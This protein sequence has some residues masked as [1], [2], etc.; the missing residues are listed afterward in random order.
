MDRYAR[1]EKYE[2]A[3]VLRERIQALYRLQEKQKIDRNKKTS[4]D[5][6]NYLTSGDRVYLMLFNIDR[7]MLI[8]KQE[9]A[10]DRQE[11][12]FTEFLMQYYSTQRV[13]R[14]L[15]VPRTPEDVLVEYLQHRNP[16]CQITVPRRGEKHKLL[17]LVYKNLTHQVF[18]KQ[19]SLEAL[20]EALHLAKPP[21]H[22]ECFDISHLMGKHTTASMVCY[23]NGFPDKSEYRQFRIRTHRRIDD[24][25]SIREVVERRYRRQKTENNPLP[26]L[27]I[28]DGG[29]AQLNAALRVIREQ[30]LK[31]P[32]IAIAKQKEEI[33]LPDAVVPLNLPAEHRGLNLVRELRDEAHR[34]ALK[35]NR[36]L[37]EKEM[38]T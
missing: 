7:G 30:N 15:I 8:N 6:V 16:R 38:L 23:K 3:L 25:A 27:V 19:E 35:Y 10:F 22:I 14:E 1:E 34:F 24:P 11:G 20:Q 17:E 28:I 18:P 31:F 29:K 32:V 4:E 37:R 21:L 36:R 13:P 26:D 9:Y 33:F 12:F 5:I 2:M